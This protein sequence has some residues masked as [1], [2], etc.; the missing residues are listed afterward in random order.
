MGEGDQ[1]GLQG[2]SWARGEGMGSL[3]SPPPATVMKLD[4]FVR[5]FLS[6]SVDVVSMFISRA[7]YSNTTYVRTRS[8]H[9]TFR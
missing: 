8:I 2:A 5:R 1:G 3:P 4:M 9:G 6:Q 7:G